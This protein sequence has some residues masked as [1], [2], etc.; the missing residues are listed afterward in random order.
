MVQMKHVNIGVV[1]L[2][3]VGSGTVSILAGNAAQIT[4]KLGFDLRVTAVCSLDAMEKSLPEGL[5][6]VVRTTD[7][8]EVVSNPDVQIVAELV[9]GVTSA[10]EIIQTAIA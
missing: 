9:G 5:E 4:Q 2:G 6:D 8:R 7:W 3:N 10:R 1:G